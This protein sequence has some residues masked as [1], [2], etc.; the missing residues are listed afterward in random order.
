L[1]VQ[2]VAKE[3]AV[4]DFLTIHAN[5]IEGA[6]NLYGGGKLLEVAIVQEEAL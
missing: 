4:T 3:E 2:Y 6:E 5:R 1:R